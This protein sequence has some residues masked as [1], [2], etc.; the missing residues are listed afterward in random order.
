M[1]ISVLLYILGLVL[2]L[3]AA[4]PPLRAFFLLNA[5]V[6]SI[7]LGLVISSGLVKGAS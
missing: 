1:D 3:L 5:A 2:A 6:V 7:A 4:I